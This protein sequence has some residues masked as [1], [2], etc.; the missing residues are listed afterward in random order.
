ML[1]YSIAGRNHF[2]SYIFRQMI[3][4]SANI[5]DLYANIQDLSANIHDLSANMHDLCMYGKVF[6]ADTNQQIV[7]AKLQIWPKLSANVASS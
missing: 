1:D 5:H 3:K 7:S 2:F 6:I 4:L